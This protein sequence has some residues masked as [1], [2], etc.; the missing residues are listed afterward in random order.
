MSL[1]ALR[2][3]TTGDG[4]NSVL[5]Q[6]VLAAQRQQEL[7]GLR[8]WWH[9]LTL[10]MQK[11]YLGEHKRSK[12]KTTTRLPQP[13]TPDFDPIPPGQDPFAKQQDTTHQFQLDHHIKQTLT[14]HGL[15]HK[16]LKALKTALIGA[17][18]AT[19]MLSKAYAQTPGTLDPN[20]TIQIT[21]QYIATR[22]PFMDRE[23]VLKH[24]TGSNKQYL[25]ELH[26]YIL[27]PE[28][29]N[30]EAP[31][32]IE[33]HREWVK[34]GG[35]DEVIASINDYVH[36]I[37]PFST[38]VSVKSDLFDAV[39]KIQLIKDVGLPN[40]GVFLAVGIHGHTNKVVTDVFMKTPDGAWKILSSGEEITTLP[41]GATYEPDL[42]M[43]DV[44]Y[45]YLTSAAG[46]YEVVPGI[47]DESEKE[48]KPLK[49]IL[50]TTP[51]IKPMTRQDWEKFGKLISEG[52]KRDEALK[53]TQ[54]QMQDLN[55][56][57]Y[58]RPIPQK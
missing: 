51:P 9:K 55:S 53:K 37:V 50:P 2:N 3:F 48:L 7:A 45:V 52:I 44:S 28:I 5:R 20:Q 26:K 36:F 15:G 21:E 1:V 30:E 32:F 6:Y 14:K 11:K 57:D 31:V 10:E 49:K 56:F 29:K 23:L 25:E 46:V 24:F 54:P 41:P 40:E 58:T 13:S 47:A 27:K 8:S 22:I 17:L 19:S 4:S 18:L 42:Y 35:Y 39:K 16:I 38:K 34:A 33:R 12:L 43:G